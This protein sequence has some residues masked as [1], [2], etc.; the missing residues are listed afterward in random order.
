VSARP[1]VAVIGCGKIAEKHLHAYS[2]LGRAEVT[3]ADIVPK[4]RR[5][6]ESYGAAWHDDPETLIE[7]PLVDVVDVC[8][9]TPSHAPLILQALEA[10]KHVFCEKPLARDLA[11]MEAI[12]VRARRNGSAVMVGYPYRFHPA[13]QVGREVVTGGILGEPYLALVRLG[14]RGSHKAW[15]HR[16]ETG[17]GAGNEMLVHALDLLLWYFG[18]FGTVESL[19]SATLLPEREI[20]GELVRAD[21]E[22]VVLLKI[23]MESGVVALCE[24][25]L[26]TP[27]YMNT[28]EVQGTNGSLMTSILD[29]LPTTVFCR[30]ARGAYQLGNNVLRFPRVDLF[31]RELGHFLA[32]L[33]RGEEPRMHSIEQS[34]Q[35]QRVIDSVTAARPSV[36]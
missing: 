21:A 14:G 20:E 23:E 32:A 4:G 3:V 29:H 5:I 16:V 18:D 24:S 19:F 31:E 33:D 22:D 8:T 35:L 9:P 30:Q 7:S 25:D 17:G 6:A 27:G 12:Q 11:E 2:K 34:V 10:G 36:A 13:L 15:K 26:L 28:I 1:H